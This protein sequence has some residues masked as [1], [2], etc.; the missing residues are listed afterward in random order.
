V[1]EFLFAGYINYSISRVNKQKKF[2]LFNAISLDRRS[3]W[4]VKR[5]E[6]MKW[7]K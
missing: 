2:A 6:K 7:T 3:D 4:P 5:Q 1:S